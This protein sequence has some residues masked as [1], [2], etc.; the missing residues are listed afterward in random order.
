MRVSVA[1]E[2]LQNEVVP[3]LNLRGSVLVLHSNYWCKTLCLLLYKDQH[4]V[5]QSPRS[6]HGDLVHLAPYG[7]SESGSASHATPAPD[8]H[9]PPTTSSSSTSASHPERYASASASATTTPITTTSSIITSDGKRA[10][11]HQTPKEKRAPVQP[12]TAVDTLRGAAD[13]L[14]PSSAQNASNQQAH[15][16]EGA[17]ERS[18]VRE[19]VRSLCPG[20]ETLAALE[21]SVAIPAVTEVLEAV[22]FGV[23]PQLAKKAIAVHLRIKPGTNTMAMDHWKRSVIP[24]L[25]AVPYWCGSVVITDYHVGRVLMLGLLADDTGRRTFETSVYHKILDQYMGR[26]LAGVPIVE[27]YDVSCLRSEMQ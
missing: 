9:P 16:Q 1:M 27:H 24:S 10:G 19:S 11:D 2:L 21:S 7:Q 8:A 22:A 25:A 3:F 12:V 14:Q 26:Y 6:V 17:E 23:R 5:V 15:A 13:S 20:A 4:E 18:S